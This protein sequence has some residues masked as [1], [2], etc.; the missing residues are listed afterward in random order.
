MHI[1][2]ASTM[3][4]S[5][6]I[7]FFFCSFFLFQASQAGPIHPHQLT[8][9]LDPLTK[10][11]ITLIRTI[12]LKKYPTKTYTVNFHYVGLDDPEKSQVLKWVSSGT[13]T[14]RNAFVIAM[15]NT[16]E[17]HEIVI[18]LRSSNILS[19]KIHNGNGFPTLTAEEQ[20]E[21]IALPL[22]YGPFINSVRKRGLNISEV[23]CSTFTVGWYG[24][25]KS[26]SRALRIECFMKSGY[27]VNIYVRPINGIIILANI[28]EMKIVEYS[29][30]SM[31][32]VP[33]AENTEYRA[34]HMKPPFGPN[35][36]SFA[37]HQPQGPG[38]KI[39][40]HTVR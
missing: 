10:Q 5:F 22:S 16:A 23:V 12:V 39:Q 17:T 15:I 36:H 24:E 8:H 29:D 37:T 33:K 31:E 7:I 21:A 32:P 9:P 1:A 30:R 11:E 18:N 6:L 34:S 27:D 14:P 40:G 19:D 38:F 20:T 2:A 28:D 25:T 13:P 35:L 4:N 3:K 26:R